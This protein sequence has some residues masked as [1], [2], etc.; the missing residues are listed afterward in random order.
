MSSISFSSTSAN[1]RDKVNSVASDNRISQ[2]EITALKE[3]VTTDA[4]SNF[5]KELESQA[6]FQDIKLSSFDPNASKLEFNVAPKTP[7]TVTKETTTTEE[8]GPAQPKKED[9]RVN[10]I[11][12]LLGS[13][14][15]LLLALSG[16]CSTSEL[17]SAINKSLKDATDAINKHGNKTPVFGKVEEETDM[18]DRHKKMAEGK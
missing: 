4:D 3:S 10:L 17:D 7:A 11:T 8:T 6:N 13:I 16:S 5:I 12:P 1:F 9:D 14:G 15:Y 2:A 18:V